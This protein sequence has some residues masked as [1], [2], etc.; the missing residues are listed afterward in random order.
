M[1]GRRSYGLPTTAVTGSSLVE[2]TSSSRSRTTNCSRFGTLHC[3]PTPSRC[4]CCRWRRIRRNTRS[5]G[6]L[7]TPSLSPKAIST[8]EG[9]IHSLAG[10]L[11][12]SFHARGECEFMS[13]FARHLPILMFM[14]IVD[15]PQTDRPR[16]PR[17]TESVTGPKKP[18]DMLGGMS[19]L[20]TYILHED[21]AFRSARRATEAED[22]NRRP[23]SGRWR[24]SATGRVGSF[25]WRIDDSIRA[26]RS[27][28]RAPRSGCLVRGEAVGSRLG[29]GSRF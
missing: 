21:A 11:I 14:R 4:A 3:R 28:L 15:L 23:R 12:E 6:V 8:L 13:Q 20:N 10:S 27:A 2:R 1:K 9:D 7:I 17:W 24:P 26:P 19:E 29:L 16:L 22:L 18:E 5:S 25:V